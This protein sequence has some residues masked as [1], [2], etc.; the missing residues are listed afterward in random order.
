MNKA[1][2][3]WLKIDDTFRFKLEA[4]GTTVPTT[5][6]GSFVIHTSH[7]KLG[8]VAPLL[9]WLEQECVTDGA[10]YIDVKEN[11]VAKCDA[12]EVLQLGLP[13]LIP[14]KIKISGIGPI[15]TATFKLNAI[16]LDARSRPMMGL[17]RDGAIIKQGANSYL[18]NEPLFS[19]I[20]HID[21]FQQTNFEDIDSKMLA[22][23]I[24]QQFLPK[25]AVVDGQLNTI[26]V[27]SANRFTL[28]IDSKGQVH[29]VLVTPVTDF[30]GDI[31]EYNSLLPKQY[32]ES[33]AKQ[34]S[35]KK[36]C[37]PHYALGQ[38][39]YVILSPRMVDAM[40]V[41]RTVQK[42]TAQE[43]LAFIANPAGKI[44]QSLE[45]QFSEEE[46]EQFFV[47]TPDFLSLRIQ[48][49]GVW[50][51]K[52]CAYRLENS[53]S[54]VPDDE[55]LTLILGEQVIEITPE[56]AVGLSDKI[57]AAIAK[58]DSTVQH[59]DQ[60][61]PANPE[62]L[63]AIQR[64][65]KTESGDPEKNNSGEAEGRAIE[66][67]VPITTDNIEE[68]EYQ[69]GKVPRASLNCDLPELLQTVSLYPHQKIGVSWLQ[70]HW[71]QGSNG[72]LLADDM[73]LGKTLQSLAFMAW[74][75]EAMNE[76][77][78]PNRPMLIVAPS[79][80]LKNWKDEEAVHLNKPGLG[81]IFEAYGS[82]MKSLSDMSA[83]ER[84]RVFEGAD[85][86]LTTYETLRDKI[87]Y[88][89]PI[90]WACVTF[91]EVQKIKNPVSRMTE[92][93]KS[94]SCDFSVAV[95]GTPVEN[96]L[97]DLW[98]IIDA[99]EPGYLGALSEFHNTYVKSDDPVAAAE[100][101][102]SRLVDEV[103]PA[104]LMRRMKEEHLQGLP[105]KYTKHYQREMT[106]QQAQD[107]S[108]IVSNAQTTTEKGR[109][110]EVIQQLRKVSLFSAEVGAEGLT[111]EHI[112]NSSRLKETIGILDAIHAKGERA[113]IFIESLKLQALL[114]PYLQ[115]RYQMQHP[116]ARINGS[117]NG[118]KRKQLVDVFQRTPE[119]EFNV[120]LLSPK[121]GGVGLTLTQA[122]H[123]IH[124]SRWWNP[125][126]EDQCSDRIYRIG[127]Q[128]P[129]YIH[130]PMAVH[131]KYGEASFDIRLNE[132]LERKRE[133]SRNLLL[134]AAITAAEIERLLGDAVGDKT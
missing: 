9:S 56:D 29:P 107:Y 15:H 85:W 48:Q 114:V 7:N 98:S 27:S 13:T 25:D 70:E 122:N 41:V 22:W 84:K 111:N 105:K 34:F 35:G 113:L 92:M 43:K 53:T 101:L 134:P 115:Q 60:E 46:V 74:I 59:G 50:E 44:A 8:S 52:L 79:G 6:W 118:A 54:W 49:L 104:I 38:G 72:V 121:A 63:A 76:D 131:P 125:A 102:K 71:R 37:V 23:G 5:N 99:V 106:L 55:I 128:K 67:L 123:V 26:T 87:L 130:Y 77:I 133:L 91:D 57:E 124:L 33:F 88:F 10:S 28:D 17:K 42:G 20:S 66:T 21:S 73:G 129:V 120:M 103:S 97:K 11:I 81:R 65:A 14:F 3:S 94:L 132:L 39:H 40:N 19:L 69:V 51:P 61:I 89:L 2:L 116:P 31:T 119:G 4:D 32:E 62:T 30:D 68:L 47:E 127:Q 16:W 100:A 86:V 18:L 80:L 126:V 95:T 64:V 117:I 45:L 36:S 82:G 75:K 96:E 110:L 93:A 112:D 109:V 78:Y 1:N 12:T 24:L 83:L 90:Q 108:V 58:G